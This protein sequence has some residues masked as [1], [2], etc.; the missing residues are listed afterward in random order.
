MFSCPNKSGETNWKRW[1]RTCLLKEQFGIIIFEFRSFDLEAGV[2]LQEKTIIVD[3]LQLMNKTIVSRKRIVTMTEYSVFISYRRDGGDAFALLLY[4]RLSAMGY[5]VFI[6]VESLRAGKFNEALLDVI[7]NCEDFILVLSK[8]AL[9]RCVNKDD[10]VRREVSHAMKKKKN[11]IPILLRDFS[12]PEGLPDDIKEICN[13]QRITA[14]ST[15]IF[16]HVMEKLSRYLDSERT[17][18]DMGKNEG[19]SCPIS[20]VPP[21]LTT[22]PVAVDLIGRENVIKAIQE[23]LDLNDIVAIRADGGVGKTAIAVKT[24]NRIKKDVMSGKSKYQHVAWITSTG[25][26]MEDLI[27]IEIPSVI[28]AQSR[29]EK[30]QAVGAFLQ[31]TPTFL[32][33]DNMDEPPTDEE[34]DYLNTIAGKT[35]ILITTRVEI[36]DAEETY[37]LSEIDEDSALILFYRHYRKGRK[38]TI[39]QIREQRDV[40]F[41]K[42]IIAA[43]RKNALLIELIGKMAYTDHWKLDDLWKRLEADVFGQDSKHFIP[44]SH[45]KSHHRDKDSMLGQI[46][47]LYEMSGLSNTQKDIMYFIALFPAEHS[48]F[49]DV[50]EWAGFEDD[51]VDD[52]GELERRGWIE[53]GDE[54]YLIHTMVQ[55]SVKLQSG[56]VK[57]DE[58]RYENL[59]DKLADTDQYISEGTVYTKVRERIVVP[60]TVCELLTDNGS[61]KRNTA[62]L[63]NNIA[64]VYYS[65]GNYEKAMEYC[66]KA[67]VIREKVLGKEHP[68]TATTYDNMAGVYE[69]QGNYEKALEYYEKA[70]VIQEEVLGDEHLPTATTYNN[71]AGVYRRQGNYEKAVEYYE[72]AEKTFDEKLGPEHPN[73]KIVKESL[74][75]TKK[76]LTNN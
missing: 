72:K 13:Y 20:D 1:K 61:E 54:G 32:I 73:T 2:I 25:S 26:L 6:D 23:L 45:G 75:A 71:M 66:E 52:L 34:I 7:D 12:F 14:T 67:L 60:E 33:I 53:R 35:K 40:P 59:I 50:F 68:D 11:I 24:A 22:I 27:G 9:D 28:N 47:Y 62:T 56:K 39:D 63:F 8:N 17:R 43:A 38:F 37:D 74:E 42:K 5:K 64:G 41:A 21:A 10:W 19:K 18:P 49:F 51:E 16:P 36:P 46:H 4:D 57:F 69:D 3:Q 76:A 30:Y 55:G 31:S 29:E 48:I 44:T 15:E 70:L 65:Q 58:E